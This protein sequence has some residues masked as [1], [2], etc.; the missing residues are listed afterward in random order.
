MHS[1]MGDDMYFKQFYL[2]CLSQASYL[3][4]SNG[5]AVVVDPQ[6][7][8]DEYIETARREGLEIRHVIETHLH[9]DFVSG[10][11]ELAERTGA[12]IHIGASAGA[13]FVHEPVRDGDELRVGD[14]RLRL[15]ETPGH[16]P[17]SISVLVFDPAAGADPVAILTGDT[18]F[19]GDVGRPDLA[20]SRGFTRE[21]MA[22]MLYDTLHEKILPLP[23][24]VE[25]YPAHGAGSAC[26]KNISK[27]THASL[28][29]QRRT[30]YAL[31]PMSKD[32]FVELV[33]ADLAPAPAYFPFDAEFNRR[34]ARPLAELAAI[35]PLDPAAARAALD[36]GAVALDVRENVV[37]GAGHIRGSIN[38]GLKGQ[39][40]SWAATLVDPNV[41]LVIVAHDEAQARE[42]VV[43]LARVGLE[44]VV[45]W[46]EGG[47][48][49]WRGAGGPV[50]VTPQITVA[51]LRDRLA[52]TSN[53][54][55]VDVRRPAEYAAGHVPRAASAPL[56]WL[57]RAI[58]PLDPARPT[59][60]ICAGGY[61]SSAAT[62][63][64]E[65]RGFG[66][67]TN[68]LGGTSAWVAAGYGTESR[69]E[70]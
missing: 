18:L 20:G 10:H 32:A 50:E 21:Q 9:A 69:G 12:T 39:F 11:C 63:L 41:D 53:L 58:A 62:S 54:Q 33:T 65:A 42:A 44:R 27:E 61:R 1:K 31:Q 48:D 17:E 4:G 30:N 28:G 22:G 60:V 24:T 19:I 29:E 16:T 59:A 5:E 15:I 70:S 7:D 25:V 52:A 55:I 46:L 3:I 34:G 6:R 49:A 8:V 47:V 14:L 23:D 57:D 2:G 40:A 64:L 67:L 56:D 13:T 45:G 66:D 68:V 36:G 37:Y 35:A 38:V 51:E 26:G 43:R